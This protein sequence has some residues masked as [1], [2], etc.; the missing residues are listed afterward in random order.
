MKSTSHRH[1]LLRPAFAA[2]L[3]AVALTA[4]SAWAQPSS[5]PLL[6]NQSGAKPNLMIA[7]D[8]SGSM[9]FTYH[10]SYNVTDD[11]DYVIN[12]CPSPYSNVDSTDQGQFNSGIGGDAIYD[13]G[14]STYT[15]YER[16]SR[17][18]RWYTRALTNV[19]TPSDPPR[20]IRNWSAQR[21]ADVNPIYYNPR[22]RYLPRVDGSG[23]VVSPRDPVLPTT[24]PASERDP[25]YN[26]EIGRAHV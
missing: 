5:R 11:A 7:L 23:N 17:R 9:A 13:A 16:Y 24:V 6:T 19:S 12:V 14:S 1:Q 8:N 21:S 10:E 3:A 15:C 22:V 25:N 20:A 26:V 4:T 18:G 2:A